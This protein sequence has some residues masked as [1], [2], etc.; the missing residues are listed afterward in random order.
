MSAVR[1]LV[2][3][4]LR[5]RWRG[6]LGLALLLGVAGGAVIAVA[7]G[8]RRTETAY[9]RFL[10]S[11]NAADVAF[12]DDGF[13]G[14]DVDLD[15]IS[16]LPQVA[17]FARAGLSFYTIGNNVSEASVDGRLGRTI[18]RF[19]LIK[20]QMY[21]P[22]K[23]DEVLLG[24]GVARKVKLKVG[25]T[26]DLIDPR[27]FESACRRADGKT[28][29][30]E[31]VAYLNSIQVRFKV[32]GI[33]AAPGE[34]P[35][36]YLGSYPSIHMTPAFF[37]KVGNAFT[38]EPA[39]PEKGSLYIRLKRGAADLPAFRAAFAELAGPGQ[40][41]FLSTAAQTGVLTRRAFHFQALALWLL[42][43][44]GGIAVLLIAGQSLARQAFL[45]STE[46][47]TLR[48]LGFDRWQL[49]LVGLGRAT[50]IGLIGGILALGIA[51]ALSPLAP[52]GDARF[53]E[54]HSGFA[55]DA[56]AL[57]A[58]AGCLA[59]L[60]LLASV[61]PAWMA[62]RVAGVLGESEHGARQRPS[63][64]AVAAVRTGL[65]AS[66]VAGARL[67]L[68]P[69]RGRTAVPVRSTLASLVIGLMVLCGA[70]TFGASLNHLLNTPELYGVRWDTQATTFGSGADLRPR[71]A[72]LKAVPGIAG[73]A[74]G[75]DQAP[76]V[77]D[78]KA[79][80]LMAILPLRGEAY[81]PIVEGDLP[82]EADE[83]ALTAPTMRR[84]GA[85]IGENVAVR[86]PFTNAK[87]V[88]FTVVGR[89]VIPP[90]GQAVIEGRPG[91]G[92]LISESGIE[93]LAVGIDNPILTEATSL[94]I[95]FAP[96]ADHDEV[97]KDLEPL[98]GLPEG[99][100]GLT[101]DKPETPGDIVTF[102]SVQNLPL[103]L[104]IV[105]GVVAAATLAHTI[106]SS[107]RRRR[108]DLA[109]LKTLGFVRGQVRST[110]A[111]QATLLTGLAI[112]VGAPAGVAFGRW[113]WSLFADQLGMVPTAFVD[114]VAIVLVAPSAFVLANLIAAIPGRA[115]ARLRPAVVL[116][117]E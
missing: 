11:H 44:F 95:R 80:P 39:G 91:E 76:A 81:P 20:G 85:G 60:A 102:G 6:W 32:V 99:D 89:T 5:A 4:E 7:A 53:A 71:V 26:F 35:P 13:L 45:G 43:A 15:K 34:F 30:P 90:S 36:Q 66:V 31:C 14:I 103:L 52:I 16:R 48:A 63:R 65:P 97:L 18:N 29:D 8:A 50:M 2:R 25:D 59:A 47:P 79:A 108:G 86:A 110:V 94:L 19:R 84:T 77:I 27:I 113:T 73:L 88:S 49:L 104:G 107:A 114:T 12:F 64:V 96:G 83:I 55:F 115:S 82:D 38:D 87:T 78:G 42:A 56:L 92:A 101:D 62:A 57:G 98:M 46:F 54:P 33:V 24:F 37:R 1:M 100:P 61:V 75:G 58:G 112:A 51:Y 93:R 41:E 106:A 72:Q 9:D 28:R 105:L 68:E 67:A 70:L 22:T 116:R 23:V 40:L 117:T 21:D 74:L 111:W 69:G 109:I 3:G 17:E 10:V